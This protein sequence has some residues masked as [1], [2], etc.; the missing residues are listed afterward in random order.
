[1][2]FRL[3]KVFVVGMFLSIS[4]LANAGLMK[5][6]IEG[7]LDESNNGWWEITTMSGSYNSLEPELTS[8]VWWNNRD[9]AVLFKNTYKAGIDPLAGIYSSVYDIYFG[10]LL[11]D[12][13]CRDGPCTFVMH[14]SPRYGQAGSNVTD[15]PRSYAI[16]HKVSEIPEPSTLAILA[17]GMIGLAS[18]QL[19]KQSQ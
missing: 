14:Q 16:A 5:V 7:A 3:L 19:K 12:L 11:K 17:L 2:K 8:Q 1:M 6:E 9:L 4:S 13:E 15:G 10:Y 18:R